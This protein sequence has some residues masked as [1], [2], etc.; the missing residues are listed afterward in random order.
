MYA[1]LAAPFSEA[2]TSMII[3]AKASLDGRPILWKHRDTSASDN[4]LYRVDK[5]GEIGY[6]ALFNGGDSLKLDEA[7]MGMN[8]CGFAIMNTVAY[9][10]PENAPECIDREGFV[11]AEALA[12]CTTVDDFGELLDRL[13]KPLGVR[14][15]FGVMDAD[16]NGA[17]FETDDYTYERFDLSDA[18]SGILIRTNYAYS[19]QPDTGMGYIRHANVKQILAHEIAT[20][21]I[22]PASLTERLSRS[23]FNSVTGFDASDSSERWAVDQDFIPRHSSTASIAI[24]GLLP[25]EKPSE[26]IMLANLGY[27]PCSH[28]VAATLD[29]IPQN[30]CPSDVYDAH[31][32]LALDAA[33][34]KMKVFPINRGNGQRYIDLE[35]VKAI[36]DEQSGISLQEYA[37]A[38]ALRAKA[39]N[40]IKRTQSNK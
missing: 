20:G 35:A 25:G 21:T 3:S 31:C 8:D 32:P 12:T 16:G 27:P 29:S 19:G 34:L 11:M 40:K 38:N 36:S 37:K 5:P 30:A 2:C 6:V 14:T 9:N 23:F 4:F 13:P 7:W 10:L 1:I 39:K 28:V 17:Y 18:P 24:E 33:E 15:N 26:T 22:T